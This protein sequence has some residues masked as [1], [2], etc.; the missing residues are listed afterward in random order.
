MCRAVG[1][2]SGI[3][4]STLVATNVTNYPNI[5]NN[6]FGSAPSSFELDEFNGGF[7]KFLSGVCKKKV[8][9]ITNTTTSNQLT[10]STDLQ[11]AGVS[12]DDYFEVVNV[13]D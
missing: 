11:S 2:V 8:Y 12:W 6:N 1:K 9:D 4:G 3:F 7:I 5:A 10:S 13:C